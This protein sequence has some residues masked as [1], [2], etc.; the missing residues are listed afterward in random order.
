MQEKTN[1]PDYSAMHARWAADLLDLK[2]K[3]VLVVGCNTGYECKYFIDYGA[4]QVHG[5]DVID[6]TG[7]DFKHDQVQYH[8]MSAERMTFP[9]D[10]FDLIYCFATMEHIPHIESAFFEM[11]RIVAQ[12]GFIYC[13]SS[14]LWNSR[15]GHHKPNFFDRCPW[16]H[17]RKSKDEI[18]EYCK[19]EGIE[20][21]PAGP[22]ME[23]HVSYMLNEAHFNKQPASRYMDV[24]RIFQVWS[25]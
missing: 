15:N 2:G 10:C 1:A 7:A 3:K 20:D 21:A 6:N 19:A 13:V 14:P 17:L 8:F 9:D 23:A 25:Y 4:Q 11:A 22:S 12:E 18:L 16:I 24:C 5:I